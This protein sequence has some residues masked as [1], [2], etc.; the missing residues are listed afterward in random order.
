MKQL[1]LIL[2]LFPCLVFAQ[3]WDYDL[4]RGKRL[5]DGKNYKDALPYFQSAAKLGSGEAMS[6]LG[7]MYYNGQGVTKNKQIALNMYT[8]S[9]ESGYAEGQYNLGYYYYT[10]RL[11]SKAFFWYE[12][13]ADNGSA[14]ACMAMAKTH[15]EGIKKDLPKALTYMIKAAECGNQNVYEIIG[16]WYY[17]GV[18]VE[19]SDFDNAFM[20]YNKAINIQKISHKSL[21]NVV[22]MYNRGLISND[23]IVHCQSKKFNQQFTDKG[24][25]GNRCITD[26]LIILD[27][28]VNNGSEEAKPLYAELQAEYEELVR[29]DNIIIGPGY[30]MGSYYT[31]PKPAYASA[32]KG[33]TIVQ[34]YISETG[35]ASG[36]RFE[37]RVLQNFDDAAM[38]MVRN[39]TF[40]PA[41]KGGKPIKCVV[42]VTVS[43]YPTNYSISYDI[44][45]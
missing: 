14:L 8:K 3:N 31:P 32:G 24:E 35:V 16:N 7:F 28:L 26:A 18:G 30:R 6:I 36:F 5:Y 22:E 21:M 39:M 19:E 11:F 25:I 41:T 43:W 23:A 44:Y 10:E 2:F 17:N 12:K 37:K 45:K 29:L 4:S 38:N 33:E 15:S 34:C 27:V 42:F 20:W 13:A 1:L 40:T 9:A